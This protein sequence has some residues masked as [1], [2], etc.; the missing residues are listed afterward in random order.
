V[1][2]LKRQRRDLKR[3]DMK[4]YDALLADHPKAL[5]S[6]NVFAA[7]YTDGDDEEW[8]YFKM[9]PKN[10][11]R[12]I[13]KA[14]KQ[15]RLFREFAFVQQDEPFRNGYIETKYAICMIDRDEQLMPFADLE[16]IVSEMVEALGFKLHWI[17]LTSLLNMKIKL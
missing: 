9:L 6:K 14:M 3:E 16:V 11:V 15:M 4:T 17:P 8:L 5:I 13:A 12:F 1:D 2:T 10:N 7:Y